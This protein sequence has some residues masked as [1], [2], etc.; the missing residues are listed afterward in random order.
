VTWRN[1]QSSDLSMTLQC[2]LGTCQLSLLECSLETCLL[3]LL[4]CSLETWLSLGTLWCSLGTLWCSLGTPFTP[5]AFTFH[6]EG[7]P[8]RRAPRVSLP[9]SKKERHP[10]HFIL[11]SK[12]QSHSFY[13][14]R[15]AVR[16]RL[17]DA[18]SEKNVKFY[19]KLEQT[20]WSV[21][22]ALYC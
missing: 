21:F 19:N 10:W 11:H 18:E 8:W 4:E 2:S 6:V 7:Y 17:D 9:E 15:C 3:S 12:G 20:E 13:W 14:L 5:L 22:R 1:W 16:C